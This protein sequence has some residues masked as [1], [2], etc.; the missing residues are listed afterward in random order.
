MTSV[1]GA[2]HGPEEDDPA[3]LDDPESN[4]RGAWYADPFGGP[5]ERWWDGTKWTRDL[6]DGPG[7]DQ[8]AEPP[9]SGEAELGQDAE[10]GQHTELAQDTESGEEASGDRPGNTPGGFPARVESAV[11]GELHVARAGT[12]PSLEYDLRSRAGLIGSVDLGFGGR[13]VAMMACAEGT[14]QL[15]KRRPHGWE[16]L[17][18][19]PNGRPVGWYSGRP[20]PPGG[21]ISF[22][23]GAGADLR[24][25]LNRQWRLQSVDG[26]ERFADIRISGE[27]PAHEVALSV[28]A[29]PPNAPLVLLTACAVLLLY[30]IEPWS[31]G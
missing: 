8:P 12:G 1:S 5:G 19:S 16:L 10:S 15:S 24:R 7:D 28:H 14:W 23:D 3:G 27:P 9:R 6:R 4:P 25:G 2:G 17:L 13:V 26:R 29:L 22:I 31:P 18:S 20:R 30:R 21:E 11:G